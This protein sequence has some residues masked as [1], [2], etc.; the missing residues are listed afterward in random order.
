MCRV[1]MNLLSISMLL[2]VT[3]SA[4]CIY[5]GPRSYCARRMATPR[6]SLHSKQPT[7][8]LVADLSSRGIDVHNV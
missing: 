6:L 1:Q 4:I 3:C 8:I 5:L 7:P 2:A